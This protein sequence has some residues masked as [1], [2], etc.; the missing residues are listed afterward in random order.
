MKNLS[1]NQSI[2][3]FVGLGLLAYLL[4]SG[5]IMSFFSPSTPGSGSEQVSGVQIKDT[6]VGEGAEAASGD[7]VTVHYVGTLTDGKVF[8]SSI[9]R[10]TPF[11]FTLGAGQVIRGWDEGL[12]GMRVGGKRT[13]TISPDYAYGQEGVG[14]IPPNSVIIFEVDLLNV[15]KP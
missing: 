5:P 2:A 11:I 4:F 1:I 15:E 6:V 7:K 3:V 10:N 8:D 14:P 12:V 13:L 9:D